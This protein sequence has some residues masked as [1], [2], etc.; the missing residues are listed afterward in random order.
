[1]VR[2]NEKKYLQAT[3]S[4]YPT[5]TWGIKEWGKLP[6]FRRK[7]LYFEEDSSS[8]CGG[9]LL[10]AGLLAFIHLHLHDFQLIPLGDPERGG[11]AGRAFQDVGFFRLETGSAGRAGSPERDQLNDKPGVLGQGIFFNDFKG[12]R[13]SLGLNARSL[14][15]TD[16]ERLHILIALIPTLLLDD[17][18]KI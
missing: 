7:T 12:K 4:V 3:G 9:P 13:K 11:A 1:M 18:Q 2:K 14:S 6:I 8:R 5:K 15:H 17:I 16:P 10:P